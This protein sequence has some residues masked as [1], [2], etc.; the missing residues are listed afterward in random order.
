LQSFP[1]SSPPDHIHVQAYSWLPENKPV[2]VLQ[3]AHGMQEHAL[4]YDHFAKWLNDQGIAVYAED[5]IGHGA[6]IRSMDEISHFPGKDDWQRSVDILYRLTQK[7]K[8]DL[9][10]VPLFLLGHSMGSVLTQSYMI[11]YGN[12]AD[13]YILSGAIRQPVF[14]ASIGRFIA[15]GLAALFGPKD[16]SRLIISL[17]YGQY[18]KKFKPNRTGADWLCRNSSAVDE[19][20]ASPLCGIPLTNRFYQNFF[21]GLIYIAQYKN[22]KQI[23][24]G[25]SVFLIAGEDDP[26][27]IF[28]IAPLKIKQ[29]LSKYAKANVDLKLFPGMRHEILNEKNREEVYNDVLK[30]IT[31]NNSQ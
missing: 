18:N 10:G 15:T 21:Y 19:Y 23:P 16:R 4:R 5:H 20:I 25:K 14:M 27:G 1:I 31:Q 30:Y 8:T 29:L 11:R 13:G 12:E 9:P 24:S 6:S 28:G 22:L 3:I 17:G 26:A 2:A 7:I